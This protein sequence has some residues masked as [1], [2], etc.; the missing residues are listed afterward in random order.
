MLVAAIF[1][2]NM[3]NPL[4]TSF[5][6]LIIKGLGYSS[7]DAILLNIPPGIV[8]AVSMLIAG[9]FLSSK[10]GQEKR[11]FVIIFCYLP[12]LASCLILY[13]SPIRDSTRSAHLYAIITVPIV[14]VSAGVMYSL[15]ASNIAGY[16]KKATTGSIFF[17]AYAVAN[18]VGP[19][20][21]LSQQAPRYQDGVAVSLTAFSC[22]IA[23]FVA[24]YFVYRF[25]NKRRE[26][27]P[28]GVV[29]DETST[30]ELIN[31]F[32]DMTDI[33]NKQLRYKL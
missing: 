21:F 7:F 19:Q 1:F 31:A 30:E 18:I 32:S 4:Q 23:L 8:Q 2:H 29:T 3:T 5:S 10:W 27:D 26:S 25:E 22:N 15:L 12:G 6:G 16:T 33:E 24:L 17:V 11:I 28:A 14:A 20:A 13:L 9:F